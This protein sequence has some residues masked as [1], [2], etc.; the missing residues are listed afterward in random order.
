MVEFQV[1]KGSDDLDQDNGVKSLSVPLMI[2][3]IYSS[4]SQ[5]GGHGPAAAASPGNL[6]HFCHMCNKISRR[7]PRV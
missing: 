7:A 6:T 4:G 3:T 5:S 2:P 1:K